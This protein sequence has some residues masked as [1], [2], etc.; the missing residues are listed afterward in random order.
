MV[1]S[2]KI[3]KYC[4]KNGGG[5]RCW[6]FSWKSFSR[7]VSLL[8]IICH[9]GRYMNAPVRPSVRLSVCP[10]VRPSVCPS[11]TPIWPPCHCLIFAKLLG[12]ISI[13]KRSVRAVWFWS[14][15]KGQGHRA[16]RN[17]KMG[18]FGTFSQIFQDILVLMNEASR[19]YDIHCSKKVQ[20][21][22]VNGTEK[23]AYLAYFY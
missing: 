21:T 3:E 22:G 19:Q 23:R 8:F 20:V 10:S 13:D 14:S 7:K 9:L 16:W 11:V 17:G 18:I 2:S 12:Y 15:E 1:F 4:I 6:W 5:G